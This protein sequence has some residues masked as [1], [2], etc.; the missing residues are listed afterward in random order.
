M[1]DKSFGEGNLH[2]VYNVKEIYY[3]AVGAWKRSCDH[4]KWCVVDDLNLNWVCIADV[5]RAQNQYHRRGGAL[6]LESQDA[7]NV[8]RALVRAH[9]PLKDPVSTAPCS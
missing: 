6:C 4:S 9:E 7:K 2:R 3:E 5:N 8:F 1:S